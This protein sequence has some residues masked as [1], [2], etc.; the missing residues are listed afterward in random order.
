MGDLLTY[1]L[2][3]IQGCKTGPG[4]MTG[5]A[6]VNHNV[7]LVPGP[8]GHYNSQKTSKR[9]S[10]TMEVNKGFFRFDWNPHYYVI[11]IYNPQ[12]PW[13]WYIYANIWGILMVNVTRY[14]YI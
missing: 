14:I 11:G 7:N 5:A 9:K 2:L 10:Q 4:S 13:C 6:G 12:D 3:N 8:A 1:N